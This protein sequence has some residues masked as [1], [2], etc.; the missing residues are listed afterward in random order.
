MEWGKGAMGGSSGVRV[1]SAP[2]MGNRCWVMQTASAEQT[3]KGWLSAAE[4]LPL[5]WAVL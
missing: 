5:S 2:V 3:A 1:V 4:G